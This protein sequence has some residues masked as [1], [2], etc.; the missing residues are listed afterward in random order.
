MHRPDILIAGCLVSF[1]SS[2]FQAKVLV[3]SSEKYLLK[4]SN[5][6]SI[7]HEFIRLKRS[8]TGVND[9]PKVNLV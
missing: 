1:Q 4:R 3:L 5:R 2:E 6:T 8:I 7:S 9:E